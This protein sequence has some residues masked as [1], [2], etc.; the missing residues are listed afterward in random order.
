MEP[1]KSGR[2]NAGSSATRDSAILSGKSMA[3]KSRWLVMQTHLEPGWS[4]RLPTF[5]HPEHK[6][7]TSPNAADHTN[8]FA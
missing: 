8:Y 5:R 1:K 2:D 3:M 6:R 4:F 7:G